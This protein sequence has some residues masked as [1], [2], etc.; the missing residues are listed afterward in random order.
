MILWRRSILVVSSSS[1]LGSRGDDVVAVWKSQLLDKVC[2]VGDELFKALIT[3]T[4]LL[5]LRQLI[6][7]LLLIRPLLFTVGEIGTWVCEAP[8]IEHSGLEAEAAYVIILVFSLVVSVWAHPFSFIW[9]NSVEL[10]RKTRPS[11]FTKGQVRERCRSAIIL[12]S[13]SFDK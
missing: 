3:H 12:K 1:N 4:P 13:W 10:G 6:L 9:E 5:L 2:L 11:F 8:L 7:L